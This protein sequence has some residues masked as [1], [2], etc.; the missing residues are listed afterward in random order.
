MLVVELLSLL[1]FLTCSIFSPAPVPDYSVFVSLIQV[2][3]DTHHH[4]IKIWTGKLLKFCS[5]FCF[6]CWCFF[7]S[8][9]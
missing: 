4:C 3:E 6:F 9:S 5:F 7:S 2:L 1:L 8:L